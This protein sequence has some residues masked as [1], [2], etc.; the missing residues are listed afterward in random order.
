MIGHVQILQ[1]RRQ[2]YKLM[3]DTA[4]IDRLDGL[5][6]DEEQQQSVPNWVSIAVD[7]PCNLDEPPATTRAL[8]TAETVTPAE[9]VVKIPVSVEGI[10]PDDR[11]TITAVADISDPEMLGAVM[12]VTH[13]RSRTTAVQRRLEC[14]WNK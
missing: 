11:V 14:R 1:L 6:W 2:A 4:A 5:V 9:P 3:L 7:V 10:E 13:N 8:V 12:W